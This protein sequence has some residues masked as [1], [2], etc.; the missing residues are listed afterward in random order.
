MTSTLSTKT[1]QE[2][3]TVW[4]SVWS[5]ISHKVRSMLHLDDKSFAML[6]NAQVMQVAAAIPFW[7]GCPNPL[8]KAYYITL[9]LV[10]DA[11][12]HD[13]LDPNDDDYRDNRFQRLEEIADIC[14]SGD[15]VRV[16]QGMNRLAACMYFDCMHDKELDSIVGNRSPDAEYARDTLTQLEGDRRPDPVYDAIIK[17]P[18]RLFWW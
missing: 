11:A 17:N 8:R 3:L 12:G 14:A 9:P 15:A 4:K 1:A 2:F 16:Q 10:A 7:A 5:H 18:E 13:I 6:Q